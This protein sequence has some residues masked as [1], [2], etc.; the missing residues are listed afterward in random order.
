MVF[1]KPITCR[2]CSLCIAS[3]YLDGFLL[4]QNFNGGQQYLVDFCRYDFT[5]TRWYML[6]CEQLHFAEFV[7]HS[8]AWCMEAWYLCD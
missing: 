7:G 8:Y 5:F 6:F 4:Y 2:K 1:S 3:D